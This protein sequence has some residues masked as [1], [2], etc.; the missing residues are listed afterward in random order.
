MRLTGESPDVSPETF[1]V[2]GS[3]R[4]AGPGRA[5]APGA[6]PCTNGTVLLELRARNTAHAAS[7]VARKRRLCPTVRP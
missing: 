1:H 6:P 7:A 5:S 4:L 3:V 2:K